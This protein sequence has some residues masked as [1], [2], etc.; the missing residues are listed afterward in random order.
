MQV[1][2]DIPRKLLLVDGQLEANIDGLST[3]PLPVPDIGLDDFWIV[4]ESG[5]ANEHEG[6]LLANPTG[7]VFHHI[8]VGGY[9][10]LRRFDGFQGYFF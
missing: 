5:G 8:E 9:F 1:Q 4:D 6:Q 7:G 2:D 3:K 10:M